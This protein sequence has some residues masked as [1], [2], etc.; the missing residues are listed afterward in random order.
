M[1][2]EVKEV[3]QRLNGMSPDIL[4]SMV[5]STDGLVI[6]HQGQVEDPDH[7]GAYF[8]EMQLVCEKIIG[9][10]R[11]GGVEEIFIRSQS[12]CVTVLP[13]LERGYLACMSTPNLNSNLFQM[14]AWK[15]VR[16]IHWL[17]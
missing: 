4:L 16:E 14:L 5:I 3:L 8:V 13:I 11:Y 17:L 6:A 15:F 1:S 9:E 7:F 10:L 2:D 12:G